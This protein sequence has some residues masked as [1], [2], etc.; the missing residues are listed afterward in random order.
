MGTH[1][2]F[3][4]DFDCLTEMGTHDDLLYVGFNQDHGCFACG[5]KFGFIVYNSYPLKVKQRRVVQGITC[6]CSKVEMLYR[7]NF[8]AL[9]GNGE[10]SHLPSTKV[11]IWDCETRK[12]VA[13]LNFSSEVRRV[14]LTKDMIIVGLDRMIKIFSFTRPPSQIRVLETGQN[15]NGLI[16]LSPTYQNVKLVYPSR[17]PGNVTIVDLAKLDEEPHEVQVHQGNV[18]ALAINS[19]G[20]KLATA[21][22]KGTLIRV[23]DTET[24]EKLFELRRGVN[25]AKT[26]SINFSMDSSLLCSVSSRGTC[27]IWKLDDESDKKSKF[28]EGTRSIS[29]IQIPDFNPKQSS[30]EA[31][32]CA[33]TSDL[34]RLLIISIDGVYH[35]YRLRLS[36]ARDLELFQRF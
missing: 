11:G 33:F 20:K 31:Y 9:I 35:R 26:Y 17:T 5:T 25:D 22:E 18:V 4:S 34:K 15:P 3:E 29:Q 7:C 21:S 27:H 2:I 14:R 12:F 30:S 10:C 8:L 24:R 32:Q 1:P 16:C 23:W 6:G 36:K 13:E 28:I 19:D